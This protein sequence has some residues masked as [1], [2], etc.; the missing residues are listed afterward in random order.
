MEEDWRGF[1]E[2]LTYNGNSS[3]PIPFIPIHSTN[4]QTSPYLYFGIRSWSTN[5][6]N[7][8]TNLI[9]CIC[10]S[11]FVAIMI[12]GGFLKSWWTV[13][14]IFKHSKKCLKVTYI[15]VHSKRSGYKSPGSTLDLGFDCGS[16]FLRI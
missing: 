10:S 3:T 11:Y 14:K 1:W 16:E 15:K 9:P 7:R 6:Y 12:D 13:P 5:I 4:S 2:I 8:C